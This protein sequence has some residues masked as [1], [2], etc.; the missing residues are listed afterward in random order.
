M[1]H[2]PRLQ[3]CFQVSKGE[4]VQTGI[5]MLYQVK[6]MFSVFVSKVNNTNKVDL[7]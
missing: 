4:P 7:I 2:K 6:K 1:K 5:R 3:S